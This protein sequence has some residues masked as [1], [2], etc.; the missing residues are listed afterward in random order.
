MRRVESVVGEAEA[1]ARK[2]RPSYEV[3][4]S[5]AHVREA[6]YT[7]LASAKETGL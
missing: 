2:P 3:T 6:L 7:L 4:H 1:R 5:V